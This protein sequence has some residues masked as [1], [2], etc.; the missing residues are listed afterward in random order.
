[1]E[2]IIE[3]VTVPD[4]LASTIIYCNILKDFIGEAENEKAV[5]K[6]AKKPIT[7]FGNL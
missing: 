5:A 6:I 3:Y 4:L 2:E 7:S 1:L